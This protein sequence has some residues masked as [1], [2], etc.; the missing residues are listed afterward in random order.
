MGQEEII[1]FYCHNCILWALWQWYYML[2][3]IDTSLVKKKLRQEEFRE[4]YAPKDM[5]TRSIVLLPRKPS[6]GVYSLLPPLSLSPYSFLYDVSRG[7]NNFVVDSN[8]FFITILHWN[9]VCEDPLNFFF[10]VNLFI[11][12]FLYYFSTYFFILQHLLKWQFWNEKSKEISFVLRTQYHFGFT[13]SCMW[14]RVGM[15]VMIRQKS[16]LTKTRSIK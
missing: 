14:E 3:G 11:C 4:I 12:L 2:V 9:C 10:S 1:R 7:S 5:Y 16:Y 6:F 15:G 8:L 13:L